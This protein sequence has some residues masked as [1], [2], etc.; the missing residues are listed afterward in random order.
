MKY[1]LAGHCHLNAMLNFIQI[2]MV[3]LSDGALPTIKKVQLTAVKLAWI[4]LHVPSQVKRNVIFG[5]IV[6]L[7]MGAILQIFINTNIRSAG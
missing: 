1:W 5:F 2:M 3:Q 7:K 4:M 6:R